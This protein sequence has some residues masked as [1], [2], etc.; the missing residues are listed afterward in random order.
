MAVTLHP[1]PAI[2]Q[3]PEAGDVAIRWSFCNLLVAINIRPTDD[4]RKMALLLHYADKHVIVLR[5]IN[6][7]PKQ[8]LIGNRM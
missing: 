5:T 6:L 2:D 3:S 7:R 8:I 4:A 1:F